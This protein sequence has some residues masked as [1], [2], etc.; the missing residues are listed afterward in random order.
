M[1]IWL[2]SRSTDATAPPAPRMTATLGSG[3]VDAVEPGSTRP[4]GPAVAG[5][6][7][8]AAGTPIAAAVTKVR[9]ALRP[10]AMP[11]R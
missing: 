9:A 7:A 4:G 11:R 2:A 6:A 1:P 3:A 10:K 5:A 8:R